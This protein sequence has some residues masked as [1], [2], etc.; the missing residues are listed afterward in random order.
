MLFGFKVGDVTISLSAI[1]IAVAILGIGVF[2]TRTLQDWL[3]EKFLPNTDLDPGIK[4]SLKT[5]IGYFGFLS[6]AAIAI[7]SLGLSLERLAFVAGAL[8]LGIGFGL[9]SIVS[10][11]VSG[12]ILLWE[13]PIRVGDLIQ[14]GAE[15][16]TVRRINVRSTEI[17]TAD[18]STIII[19]NST[20]ISGNVTNRVHTDR[21]SRIVIPV[22]VPR[23]G[24][25]QLVA[26]LL[27]Q[28]AIAHELVMKDPKPRV[29][30]KKIADSA[31]EFELIAF[32]GD[33]D[34]ALQV[35]S[36]LHFSI[37]QA[38]RDA[39]VPPP[40][41]KTVVEGI[42]RLDARL[43]ELTAMMGKDAALQKPAQAPA[44][45]EKLPAPPPKQS[46][47]PSII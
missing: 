26:E 17:I 19:P 41:G 28:A 8:S 46:E 13:R 16:G 24:D 44:A 4:N 42:D 12:L 37:F 36:D 15:S 10:N 9:Q 20:L 35:N 2:I 1:L 40:G 27:A 34:V 45:P 21:V 5:A 7:S 31:M 6:A 25:P 39:Q 32:V 38:M 11:F 18:R 3:N 23:S 30:F 14:V 22:S 33:V 47:P 43:E 29:L